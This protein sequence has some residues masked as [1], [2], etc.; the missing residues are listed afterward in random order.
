[1][2]VALVLL[3][4]IVLLFGAGLAAAK[5]LIWL[6]AI[7]LALWLIGWFVGA[8]ASEGQRRGWYRW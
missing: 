5:L 8:G 1:M 2:V 3:V 6:A 7:L 4:L